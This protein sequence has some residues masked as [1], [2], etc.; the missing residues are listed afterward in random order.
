MKNNIQ[1]IRESNF[2]LL[3]IIAMFLVLVVHADYLSIGRPTQIEIMQEPICSIGRIFIQAMSIA[4]V[5][6]FV[7]IS[8]WFG[9]KPSLKS[10]S[11]FIFQCLFFYI[12]IYWIGIASGYATFNIK[13]CV[14]SFA[15]IKWNWFIYSYILL[16]IL[17]P[18]LNSYINNTPQKQLRNT[19]IYFYIFQTIF[20]FLFRTVPFFYEGYST[21]SFIGLYMLARYVKLYP[22]KYTTFS[23][24]KDFLIILSS[25]ILVATTEFLLVINNAPKH[26]NYNN[27]INPLV[28]ISALYTLLAFSK[29]KFNNKFINWIATSCF[30]VYLI[31]INPLILDKYLDGMKYI[32]N[33]TNGIAYLTTITFVLI[34]IFTI[35]ILIDKSRI[36]V[37][38][39]L[40]KNIEKSNIY[41]TNFS[42]KNKPSQ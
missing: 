26:F 21:I 7:L 14:R 5:N 39:L 36:F 38:N 19:I 25:I 17:A 24:K 4:C 30:A 6:I 11:N 20:G 40:W 28:I 16:Y 12:G 1:K 34:L 13:D 27:Y 15:L 10:F 29:L 32:Y 18:V 2:E 22:N 9:I 37:W 23:I 42:S 41:Q 35:S 3:R 31:H 33:N 8:G